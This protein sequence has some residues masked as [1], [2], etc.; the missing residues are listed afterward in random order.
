MHRDEP[1][2]ELLARTAG[3]LAEIEREKR[4]IAARLK[5]L[6]ERVYSIELRLRNV[7]IE[8]DT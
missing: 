8:A 3:E 4:E 1:G 6:E 5:R 7:R 2:A